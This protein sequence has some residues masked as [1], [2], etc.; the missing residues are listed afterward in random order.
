MEMKNKKQDRD[1]LMVT[2]QNVK[3]TSTKKNAINAEL[4]PALNRCPETN[5]RNKYSNMLSMLTK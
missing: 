5:I 4:S 1:D 3:A 2:L